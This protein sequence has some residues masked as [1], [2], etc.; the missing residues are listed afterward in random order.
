MHVHVLHVDSIRFLVVRC[1][2]P[3]DTFFAHVA[4]D[5]VDAFDD[6]VQTNIEFL[7]LNK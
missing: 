7:V 6:D 3:C 4:F 5:S 2:E 1:A